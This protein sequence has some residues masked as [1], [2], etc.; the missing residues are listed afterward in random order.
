MN[1]LPLQGSEDFADD[2]NDTILIPQ[3][4]FDVLFGEALGGILGVKITAPGSEIYATCTPHTETDSDVIYL[5][6]WMLEKLGDEV[7]ADVQRADPLPEATGIVARLIDEAPD[8]DVRRLLEECL[9]DFRYINAN[10]ILNVGSA[11]R[12]WIETVYAGEETVAVARLGT[13]LTLLVEKALTGPVSDEVDDVPPPPVMSDEV[14]AV[15]EQ[16]IQIPDAAELR[17]ARAAYY[18]AAFQRK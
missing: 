18:E 14:A 9:Y 7:Q 1:T 17:R 11:A 15:P 8:L 4:H 2:K 12:V 16:K 10:T 6:S 13:E 3:S 5:P